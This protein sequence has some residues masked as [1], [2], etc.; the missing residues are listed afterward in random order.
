MGLTNGVVFLL[1]AVLFIF[2][3]GGIVSVR[4]AERGVI[5]SA[6]RRYLAPIA[7]STALFAALVAGT[8]LYAPGGGSSRDNLVTQM[9]INAVVVVGIQIYM[10]N[11]GVLS[12]G[13][14]GFG[15]V[16]A[17]VFALFAIPPMLKATIIPDAPLGL[18]DVELARPG[19]AGRHRGR[20]VVAVIVGLG[21][22]RSGA[23]S[24]AVAATVITLALLFVV[25]GVLS[26][27][28]AHR[29]RPG[30]PVVL[31]R[32]DAGLAVARLLALFVAI[33]AGRLFAEARVGRAP[34]A[35]RTICRPGGGHQPGQ[36]AD[37]RARAV[38]RHRHGGL[39]TA[40]LRARHGHA[41]VLLPRL[42]APDPD[43]ADRGRA[44]GR[45]RTCSSVSSSS[46]RATSSRATWPA[47]T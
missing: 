6:V 9:L 21:L 7:G 41:Q 33:V 17:Y 10:G 8:S 29:R 15:R 24:G 40:G 27:G 34:P 20:I 37:G 16:A 2:R 11:T 4:H 18:A 47:P 30:R 12:F 43:D 39:V 5:P 25:H 32:R 3:P 28:R 38:G 1:I 31:G 23:Q 44:Q 13:H 46:R 26:T 36:P 14:I 35:A 45:D 22:V 19:A 42:H